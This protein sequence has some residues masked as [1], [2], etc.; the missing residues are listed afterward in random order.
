MPEPGQQPP[1]RRATA[2]RYEQ[3]RHAPEVVAT[4]AGL[5]AD[6]ILAAAREAGVPVR[7]DPALVQALAALDLGDEVPPALWT[8]VAETLAWAYRLDATAARRRH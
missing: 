8:A 5:I 7:H 4:G 1:R 2:V 6:R 3:G